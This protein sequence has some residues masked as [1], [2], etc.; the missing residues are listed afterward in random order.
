MAESILDSVKQALGVPVEE[1]AF[2]SELV[3]HI[4][5]QLSTL[6]QLGVGPADGFMITDK[7][8]T[9]E[10]FLGDKL[11]KMNDAKTFMAFRVKLLYDPPPTSFVIDAMKEQIQEASW[12]LNVSRE[13]TDWVDPDPVVVV[14]PDAD[15]MLF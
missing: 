10:E 11:K 13:E 7:S 8:S 6:R 9:W 15:P 1:T 3:L 5:A 4:N 2:D 12:R 14:D